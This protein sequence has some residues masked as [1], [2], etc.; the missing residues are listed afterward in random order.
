MSVGRNEKCICGSE[1]KY[2]KCCLKKERLIKQMEQNNLRNLGDKE[3]RILQAFDRS[4]ISTF[5]E[6]K[7]KK[8]Q[9]VS[10]DKKPIK[11]HTFPK[12]I[13]SKQISKG[14]NNDF[15]YST[16]IGSIGGNIQD[17][18][19]HSEILYPVHINNAGTVPLFCDGHDS[20]IFAPIEIFNPNPII[21]Q[22]VF[23]FGYRFFLYHYLKEKFAASEQ[24]IVKNEGVGNALTEKIINNR[25]TI[26]SNATEIVKGIVNMQGLESTKK[27]FDEV[28]SGFLPSLEKINQHFKIYYYKLNENIEWCGAGST[29]F[30]FDG[31][32]VYSHLPSHI[33][34]IPKNG[35]F[36]AIFFFIVPNEENEHLAQTIIKE[37]NG[38]YSQYLRNA[39]I[40]EFHNYIK[41]LIF[42]C[43]ENIM[44]SSNIFK[45]LKKEKTVNIKGTIQ[46]MS[47]YE[48]LKLV[49]KIFVLDKMNGLKN[50]ESTRRYAFELLKIIELF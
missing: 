6:T 4:K 7:N 37:L 39:K 10:C 18:N 17:K 38:L 21:E 11:S 27:K 5:L 16:D 22:Y 25:N 14:S 33:G 50:A 40:Q 30:S 1:K 9:Y 43:S 35:K 41:Y 36:Q 19:K 29:E 46:Q 34:L 24:L 28:M 26:Y 15:I 42:N 3:M 13:L 2:K 8:C 23:L 20:E 49:N 45:R 47:Q 31:S 12:N 48:V 44:M 32:P